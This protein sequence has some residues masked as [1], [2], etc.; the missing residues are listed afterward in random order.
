MS[1]KQNDG[2]KFTLSIYIGGL[3]S[4]VHVED[5]M[6]V[7]CANAGSEERIREVLKSDH[8]QLKVHK[9]LILYRVNDR[10]SD[11][12]NYPMFQDAEGF[13]NGIWEL[14]REDVWIENERGGKSS[15]KGRDSSFRNIDWGSTHG[16]G[17]T[18]EPG[19]NDWDDY[20]WLNPVLNRQGRLAK[21]RPELI[22]EKC[23]DPDRDLGGRLI[24]DRGR[25]S[26]AGFA[27]SS[28]TG[29]H[30][31][32]ANSRHS[33]ASASLARVD[34]PIYTDTV[35]LRKRPFPYEHR[36]RNGFSTDVLELKPFRKE[37]W[38]EICLLN[39]EFDEVVGQRATI[40]DPRHYRRL[41]SLELPFTQRL[42]ANPWD[43]DIPVLRP[44]TGEQ[45]YCRRH[46]ANHGP[47]RRWLTPDSG[48]ETPP[49][50]GSC[51]PNRLSA[52]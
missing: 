19:E 42:M 37:K 30:Y 11:M 48:Q 34:I 4:L 51:E 27:Y 12:P 47:W 39:T 29:R 1:S 50:T 14:N 20:R 18:S 9:P 33:Q 13:A 32:Y 6:M 40:D 24:L 45:H 36:P 2:S 23:C 3:C 21:V 35:V 15:G 7:L 44:E 26:V 46:M 31:I 17:L 41:S 10:Y 52:I 28:E 22:D 5:K 25:L 16:Q 38:V 43:L 49:T 8:S